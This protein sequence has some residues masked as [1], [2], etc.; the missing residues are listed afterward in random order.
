MATAASFFLPSHRPPSSDLSKIFARFLFIHYFFAG[1]KRN[2]A[3]FK[4]P[5]FIPRTSQI[6]FDCAE[7]L[8]GKLQDWLAGCWY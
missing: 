3:F 8:S 2:D 6:L 7:T 1:M 4:K 5:F